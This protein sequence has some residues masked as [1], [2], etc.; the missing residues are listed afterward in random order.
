MV[1]LKLA[2]GIAGWRVLEDVP[3]DVFYY[4]VLGQMSAIGGN[5]VHRCRIDRIAIGEADTIG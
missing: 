3:V 5:S 4:K 1:H 2:N